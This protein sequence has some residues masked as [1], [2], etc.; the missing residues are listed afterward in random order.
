MSLCYYTSYIKWNKD[1]GWSGGCQTQICACL[2]CI[3]LVSFS[4]RCSWQ[5]F[6]FVGVHG[7]LRYGFECVCV[8][9]GVL[10]QSLRVRGDTG[11]ALCAHT[12]HSHAGQ[13]F[14]LQF[15]ACSYTKSAHT[16]NR[17]ILHRYSPAS[18]LSPRR[19]ARRL[20]AG[21]KVW[22]VNLYVCA[23]RCALQPRTRVEKRR[24]TYKSDSDWAVAESGGG[25]RPP[26][27]CAGE[28]PSKHFQMCVKLSDVGRLTHPNIK[29]KEEE[30]N[31]FV[32]WI[33]LMCPPSE[34]S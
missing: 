28:S 9:A 5:K 13:Q 2:Y 24:L 27:Q 14:K 19:G 7:C 16:H 26:R 4:C 29:T 11:A 20:L 23:Y 17:D 1:Y 10:S 6:P 12:R 22:C 3:L 34:I 15:I 8:C 32:A 25:G 21:F 31:H 30:E 18:L 33:I